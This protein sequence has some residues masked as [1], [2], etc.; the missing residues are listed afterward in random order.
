MKNIF[1]ITIL[2]LIYSCSIEGPQ[3]DGVD[4]LQK[5]DLILFV[6]NIELGWDIDTVSIQTNKD[7][8]ELW[9]VIVDDNT[10]DVT[11]PADES[12][13]WLDIQCSEKTLTITSNT[14]NTTDKEK[15]FIIQLK[16]NNI[17]IDLYG[18]REGAPDD[19]FNEKVIV[20][21][22]KL[23]PESVYISAKGGTIR[24]TTEE[25]WWICDITLDSVTYNSTQEEYQ[26]CYELKMFEKTI[27]WLTVKREDNDII[28]TVEPNTSGKERTFS[29]N[30]GNGDYYS[31]LEGIQSAD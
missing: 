12:F 23:K 7:G 31:R 10:Y 26:N 21:I 3:N 17:I 19:P 8:W 29:V 6:N 14:Y 30:L 4:N 22:I 9:K 2:L 27:E 15:S 13:D 24:A 1:Y 25:F 16:Y 5:E 11:N 18:T 20:D 28:L